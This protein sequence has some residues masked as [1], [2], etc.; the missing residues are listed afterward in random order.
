MALGYTE[1]D[2]QHKRLLLLGADLVEPLISSA[3][4]KPIATRLHALI[5]FAQGHFAFEEGLMRANAYPGADEHAIFHTSLLADL[6]KHCFRLEQGLPADTVGLISFLWHWIVLHIVS[7]D[8]VLV[9]WLKSHDP[10]GGRLSIGCLGPH[11]RGLGSKY[12]SGT[13]GNLEA[14]VRSRS[15]GSAFSSQLPTG[16]RDDGR[17][18]PKSWCHAQP[19]YQGPE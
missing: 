16:A 4:P 15:K 19:G 1:I 3:A 17:H 18:G 8:R 7:E 5:A 14:R 12:V 13:S 10:D 2:E 6:R 11:Y 9:N